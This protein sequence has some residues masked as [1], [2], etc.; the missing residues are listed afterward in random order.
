MNLMSKEHQ[1]PY[2]MDNYNKEE[3][4]LSIIK[5]GCPSS[6]SIPTTTAAGTSFTLAALTLDTSCLCNP[7]IILE[8]ASNTIATAF[9]GTLNISVFKQCRC[10]VRPIPIGGTWTLQL[11]LA[12][13]TVVTDARTFSFSICDSDS[14]DKDCCTYTVVATVVAT[15]VGAA[16]AGTLAINNATLGAIATCREEC[17]EC[18][19]EH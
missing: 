9:R 11:G 8:F 7:D 10:Q 19:R 18:K 3:K 4:C 17:N 13:G 2:K 1:E 5:C 12:E 6:T 16:T 15:V 14:C